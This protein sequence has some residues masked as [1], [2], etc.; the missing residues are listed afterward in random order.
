V[1][2][3]KRHTAQCSAVLAFKEDYFKETSFCFPKLFK[4]QTALFQINLQP[5]DIFLA[6]GDTLF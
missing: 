5:P 4:S 3:S 2:R 6:L 1:I